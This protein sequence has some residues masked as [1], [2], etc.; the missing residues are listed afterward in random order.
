MRGFLIVH[1]VVRGPGNSKG[2]Y[3]TA[4]EASK[5]YTRVYYVL[6]LYIKLKRR[7]DHF[8]L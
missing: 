6:K 3:S 5:I 8:C 1:I 2:L 7:A 4:V